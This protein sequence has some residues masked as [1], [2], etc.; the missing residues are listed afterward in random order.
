MQYFAVLVQE[1]Q[2]VLCVRQS[3]QT[4]ILEIPKELHVYRYRM[5]RIIDQAIQ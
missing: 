5:S 3:P 4:K 2:A 1:M